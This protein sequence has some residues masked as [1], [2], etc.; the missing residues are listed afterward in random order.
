MLQVLSLYF[1]FLCHLFCATVAILHNIMPD[2][3]QK[4]HEHR[5]FYVALA[6]NISAIKNVI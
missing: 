6:F 4:F 3:M 5:L 2:G 1:E